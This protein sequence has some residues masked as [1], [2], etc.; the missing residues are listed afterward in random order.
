M[1]LYYGQLNERDKKIYDVLLSAIMNMEKTCFIEDVTISEYESRL[2]VIWDIIQF[3]ANDYPEI[4]WIP[5]PVSKN[6][7]QNGKNGISVTLKYPFGKE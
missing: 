4:F 7:T 2:N 6:C 5:F 3:I 1:I